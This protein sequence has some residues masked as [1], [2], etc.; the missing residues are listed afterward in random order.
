MEQVSMG[1]SLTALEVFVLLGAMTAV[2]S[3]AVSRQ[4]FLSGRRKPIVIAVIATIFSCGAVYGLVKLLSAG[5]ESSCADVFEGVLVQIDGVWKGQTA[6]LVR[7]GPSQG[8]ITPG[9]RWYDQHG[10]DRLLGYYGCLPPL[11]PHF[12]QSR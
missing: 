1:R 2:I 3:W 12:L 11:L 9:W 8:T 10:M 4:M 6:L 7:W 5:F